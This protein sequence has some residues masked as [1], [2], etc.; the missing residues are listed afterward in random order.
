MWCRILSGPLFSIYINDLPSVRFSLPYFN[1]Y[2]FILQNSFQFEKPTY[3]I[4]YDGRMTFEKCNLDISCIFNWGMESMVSF[5]LLKKFFT[6]FTLLY[7]KFRPCKTFSL[8]KQLKCSSILD[9]LEVLFSPEGSSPLLRCWVFWCT[10]KINIT[11]VSPFLRPLVL[12]CS[13]IHISE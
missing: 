8:K 3:T 11:S 9:I 12:E 4:S 13:F 5:N 10:K 1:A 6:L 7:M 2:D